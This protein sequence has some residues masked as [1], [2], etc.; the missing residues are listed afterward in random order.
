MS[1]V[2]AVIGGGRSPEHDVAL[3]GAASVVDALRASG[4]RAVPVTID[5]D[6]VWR[7]EGGRLGATPAESV[8]V[9]IRLLATCDAVFPVLHGAHGEDGT[10]AALLDLAG[11]PVVGC[12]TR[13]GAIAMDKQAT[14]ALAAS[15]GIDTAPGI[16]LLPGDPLP[17][18]ALPAVVKPTTAGSSAGVAV[19]TTEDALEPAV[20]AAR[21]FGDTV[22]VEQYVRGR[23]VQVGVVERRDGTLLVTPPIEYAVGEGE[24]F[25][26][27]RKYD[28]TARVRFPARVDDSVLDE[29][30]RSALRLFRAL[31]C[32][33]LSRFDFFVTDR[34]LLLN[35]VNT[36]PG[37][38]AQSGFPR[39]CSAAGLDHP[40]LVAELVEVAVA[41]YRGDP[42]AAIG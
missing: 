11:L 17:P 34:G 5:R 37:M 26:T 33:G 4:L 31:G 23:E 12:G 36:M 28:G 14:K 20:A 9:G 16:L 21:G 18:V 1:R 27:S 7:D 13:A 10:L 32:S 3:R 24:V 15:L 25:D 2:V 38:T 6:G 29:I 35:E 42:P 39:M 8:A 41:R 19:V 30:R 22:L 40:A